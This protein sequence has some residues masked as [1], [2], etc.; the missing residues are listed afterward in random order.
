MTAVEAAGGF[1]TQLSEI[2]EV[3]A[4]HG[5]NYEVLV[6]RFFRKDRAVMFELAGKLDL[7]AT[8]GTR[9]WT[10]R[11]RWMPGTRTTPTW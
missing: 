11:P 9:T 4:S 2:E 6:H 7:V 3:S 1:T 10:R 5:D 8:S